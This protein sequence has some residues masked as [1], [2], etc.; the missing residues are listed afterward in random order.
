MREIRRQ[1]LQAQRDLQSRYEAPQ[2]LIDRLRSEGKS[3]SEIEGALF[4]MNRL[5]GVYEAVETALRILES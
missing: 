2:D 4:E 1:L 5:K 3:M